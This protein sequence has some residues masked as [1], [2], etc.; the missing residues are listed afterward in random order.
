VTTGLTTAQ[1]VAAARADIA[2]IIRT[3]NN[4]NGNIAA[5]FIRL[6]FHDCVGGCDG[7]VDMANLDNTGLNLP[8]ASLAPVVTKYATA[9]T[10]LTRA[11][12]WALA[13]LVAA[14]N[15]QGNTTNFDFPLTRI[16]RPVC[17]NLTNGAPATLAGPDRKLP[18]A[19]VTT[20][21]LLDFF[22][23]NFGFNDNETVAIMGAHT[24]YVCNGTFG[25]E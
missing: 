11:D 21:Q 18:S 3:N 19:H 2:E 16:G 5:K 4:A 22:A 14:Q 7:C 13:G 23:T 6:S 17:A 12:V 1:V 10:A 9:N 20:Q 24:V 15:S 8:I 25:G